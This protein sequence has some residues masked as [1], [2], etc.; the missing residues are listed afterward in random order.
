VKPSSPLQSL[1]GSA[2]AVTI[3]F[4]MVCAMLAFAVLR[5]SVTERRLNSRAMLWLAARNAAEGVAEY[6]FSQVR[7]DFET[8]AT[9]GSFKPGLANALNV[10]N[11]SVFTGSSVVTGAWNAST[12][13]NGMELIGGPVVQIPSGSGQYYVDPNNY[14]NQ[15]DPLKSKWIFRQDVQIIARATVTAP[16][17]LPIT[18]YV[19]ET[20]SIRGAPLFAHAIFY[21]GDLEL[22]PGPQMDIYGPVHSNGSMYFS[23]QSDADGL[24]FHGPVTCVGNIYHAWMSSSA[25]AQGA[26]SETLGQNPVSFINSAGAQVNMKA[27][28]AST[29]W[30]DSTMGASNAVSGATALRALV[31][32]TV[33]SSFRQYAAA[34]WNGNLLTGASGIM[35][36][37]PIAF[38][39]VIDASGN[40]PDPHVLI[41]APVTPATSD[42]YYSPK[43]EV[44]AQ[45]KAMQAGLYIK[46][47]VSA[48]GSATISLYGPPGSAPAGAL[49]SQIGPNGGYLLNPPHQR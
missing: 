7:N 23:N 44:E 49:S 47:A 17:G 21:T 32:P 39:Q 30:K 25:A 38:N 24:N 3:L 28:T 26:G 19:T 29:S 42:P 10:P 11:A 6:G 14:N 2:L 37:N 45:K 8:K 34:T 22:A 16:T 46:V 41:D 31:T 18:H 40:R 1:R 27:S 48:A 33:S 20:I 13:P 43:M 5:W 9:P 15:F 35:P 12:N 4:T 36:Y